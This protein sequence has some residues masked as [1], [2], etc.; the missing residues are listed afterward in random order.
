MDFFE[1]ILKRGDEFPFQITL[2]DIEQPD[3]PLIYIN[4]KFVELTGYEK[5]E[6]L[7][8]NCRFLQSNISDDESRK[9]IREAIA[10]RKPIRVDIL[11]FKKNGEKFYNRLLL[12]PVGRNRSIYLGLQNPVEER[13]FKNF[14]EMSDNDLMDKVVN[15][16]SVLMISDL[17][18]AS[19]FKSNFTS[20]VERLRKIIHP[21]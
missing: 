8:R 19:V 13:E 1:F 21:S 20:V 12:I 16:L 9:K 11:N 2:A 10:H 17:N 7:G 5:S 14:P 3:S 4:K 15:P 18:D 6:A